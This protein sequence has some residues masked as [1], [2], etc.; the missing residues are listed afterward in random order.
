MNHEFSA[1]TQEI[2]GRL[3]SS[4][5]V[6]LFAKTGNYDLQVEATLVKALTEILR[7]NNEP[8]FIIRTASIDM[9]SY[10]PLKEEDDELCAWVHSCTGQLPV[11]YYHWINSTNV[12]SAA[13][14]SNLSAANLIDDWPRFRS[15]HLKSIS[16]QVPHHRIILSAA[17]H[18]EAD[19]G[20]KLAKYAADRIILSMIDRDADSWEQIGAVINRLSNKEHE[21]FLIAHY[22]DRQRPAPMTFL[23]IEE[24]KHLRNTRDGRYDIR[25]R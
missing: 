10:E 17:D 9:M 7:D 13:E 24:F 4:D 1:I 12:S 19:D 23:S 22:D 25:I 2:K 18:S 15:H 5:R 14:A 21:K 20:L 16:K 6:I 8:F 11:F 3:Q